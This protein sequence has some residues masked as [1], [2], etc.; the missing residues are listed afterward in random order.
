M[1]ACAQGYAGMEKYCTLTNMPKPITQNSYNKMV[2][3]IVSSVKD[4][5]KET[6][7]DAAT[8]I[9]MKKSADS[10]QVLDIGVLN[11]GS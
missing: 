6:F 7:Q 2:T 9:P 1:R 10:D 5:A 11:D 3:T 4:V 8:E